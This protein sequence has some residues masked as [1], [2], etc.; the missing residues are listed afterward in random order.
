MK[1]VTHHIQESLYKII[2]RF[3]AKPCKSEDNG[4]IYSEKKKIVNQEYC[5][6]QNC[7]SNMKERNDIPHTKSSIRLSADLPETV[8]ANVFK[9]LKNKIQPRFVC[10]VKLYFKN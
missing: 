7:P 5:I 3:S 6:W 9:A 2:S 10:P 4:M 1:K 8:E